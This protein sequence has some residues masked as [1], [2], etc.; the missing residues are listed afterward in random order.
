MTPSL[1]EP[2]REDA[3]GEPHYTIVQVIEYGKACAVAE[4]AHILRIVHEQANTYGKPG[5]CMA[6]GIRAKVR[7]VKPKPDWS[8]A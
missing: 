7:N 6:I 5:E 2:W 4:Q 1:P 8:A 3:D